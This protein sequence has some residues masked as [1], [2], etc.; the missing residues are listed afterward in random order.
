MQGE[1]QAEGTHT[2]PETHLYAHAQMIWQLTNMF[3]SVHC[4]WD[5]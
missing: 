4:A 1:T 3:G 5:E 2:H